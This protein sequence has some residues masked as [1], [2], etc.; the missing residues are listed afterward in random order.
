[1]TGEASVGGPDVLILK[2]WVVLVSCQSVDMTEFITPVPD[3]HWF[4]S[5]FEL[6]VV[7]AG[8]KTG[9]TAVCK[10]QVGDKWFWFTLS[11]KKAA[12]ESNACNLTNVQRTQEFDRQWIWF[13]K[14]ARI[15]L[16]YAP[17]H[18][19]YMCGILHCILTCWN[20]KQT[21]RT[22]SL[23]INEIWGMQE[24]WVCRWSYKKQGK[25]KWSQ[26]TCCFCLLLFLAVNQLWLKLSCYFL[27]DFFI[28]EILIHAIQSHLIYTFW[29]IVNTLEIKPWQH[30]CT[31]SAPSKSELTPLR[32]CI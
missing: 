28:S 32:D 17:Q 5:T 11:N 31:D 29:A 7:I 14:S 13:G 20:N 23:Q 4:Y 2:S 26:L 3:F 18:T 19:V 16:S 1:M 21:R 15:L 9:L 24:I 25:E 10:K 22:I 8:N 30:A 27:W 6:R 12:P